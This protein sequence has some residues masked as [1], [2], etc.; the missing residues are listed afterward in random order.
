MPSRVLNILSGK[1]AMDVKLVQVKNGSAGRSFSISNNVTIIG[2]RKSCD[3]YI[4]LNSVS[5]KHCQLSI[6]NGN[7]KIRDLGSR[8]GTIVNGQPVDESII[9]PGDNVEIG[10]LKFMLQIDGKPHIQE[11][12]KEK[13]LSALETNPSK[14]SQKT[15]PDDIFE[16]FEEIDKIDDNVEDNDSILDDFFQSTEDD[17]E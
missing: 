4:P 10:P 7:L 8:N 1:L 9:N 13:Q 12:S 3:F 2:R 17:K 6:N 5:R 11:A 15:S 14:E 16:N